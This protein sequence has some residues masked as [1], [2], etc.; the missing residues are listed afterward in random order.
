MTHGFEEEDDVCGLLTITW[1]NGDVEHHTVWDIYR[2]GEEEDYVTVCLDPSGEP[3]H[4]LTINMQAVRKIEFKPASAE[5]QDAVPDSFKLS[6]AM[7]NI[8]T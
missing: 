1:L 2:N 8:A 7:K 4:F 5:K 6:A 3:G